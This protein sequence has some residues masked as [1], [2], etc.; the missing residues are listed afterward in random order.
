[1]VE[2]YKST[3]LADRPS[4]KLGWGDYLKE[5]AIGLIPLGTAAGAIAFG[6][7]TKQKFFPLNG[8]MDLLTSTY[9]KLIEKTTKAT[10]G[11][12]LKIDQVHWTPFLSAF[13][14]TKEEKLRIS[15]HYFNGFKGFEFGAVIT[16]FHHWRKSEKKRLDLTSTYESLK[17]IND[18]KPS[19]DELRTENAS[20]K[21]Q[22]AYVRTHPTSQ[23]STAQ[24]AYDGPMESS[25]RAQHSERG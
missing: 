4:Q 3:P 7:F 5:V 23:I 10:H 14:R 15:Q 11:K 24:K 25:E 1:M 8:S 9:A 20:L 21:Q 6:K 17:P 19:D 16:L 12:A 2:T 22:L 13:G 18:L